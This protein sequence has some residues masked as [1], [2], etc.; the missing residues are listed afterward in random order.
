M[1]ATAGRSARSLQ[2]L[3]RALL[4]AALAMPLAASVAG[5]A[6]T[7]ASAQASNKAREIAAHF[8]DIKTM[9]GN[10]IQFDPNGKTTEGKFYIERP[11]NIRFDYSGTPLRVIADGDQVAINN[12]KLNT[13][14]LYPLS[15]TPLK[16]LLGERIDLSSANIRSVKEE[17]DVTTIVMGDKSVFG[18]SEIT[19]LFDTASF[20]LRQWTIKDNDGRDTT[21]IVDG[22]RAGVAFDQSMFKI[23]Y[24]AISL[25][26]T[27]KK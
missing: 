18:N 12:R 10:F 11:G 4:G 14:D 19:M 5:L 23:P 8:S 17:P 7:P 6:S 1:T 21:V 3:R 25:G 26:Q 22:L 13:W 2:I 9:T 15:K 16:L 24:T 20:D 27:G